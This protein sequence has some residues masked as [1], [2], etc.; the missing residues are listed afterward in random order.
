MEPVQKLTKLQLELIKLFSNK[1]S[2]EQLMDIKRMLSD[3]FFDQADQEVDELF[4]EKGWGDKKINE[5]SK[6]HMRTKYTPE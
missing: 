2:D 5:W 4:D 1:V 3:Y 6:E